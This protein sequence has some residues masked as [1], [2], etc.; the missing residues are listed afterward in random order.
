M[1]NTY[2]ENLFILQFILS[3]MAIPTYINS[4][5][6]TLLH[7]FLLESS[8]DKNSL[9]SILEE[10][11]RTIKILSSDNSKYFK[12]RVDQRKKLHQSKTFKLG[13]Y[14]W[15]SKSDSTIKAKEESEN[16]VIDVLLLEVY[17]V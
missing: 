11:S 4:E 13:E 5:E 10:I 12:S 15:K 6:S 3:L 17:Y 7:C 14:Y 1:A 9:V 8:D 16:H 2:D